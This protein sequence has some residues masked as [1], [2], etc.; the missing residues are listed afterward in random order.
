MSISMVGIALQKAVPATDHWWQF[1]ISA[2]VVMRVMNK[3]SKSKCFLT[4]LILFILP[5]VPCLVALPWVGQ[6]VDTGDFKDFLKACAGLLLILGPPC[7]SGSVKYFGLAIKGALFVEPTHLHVRD[8]LGREVSIKWEQVVELRILLHK[9]PPWQFS[10]SLIYI[11]DSGERKTV[12]IAGNVLSK[13]EEVRD[14]IIQKACL[15]EDPKCPL[16]WYVF[17]R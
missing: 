1:D 6:I 17:K 2:L 10:W 16:G 5:S 3:Y 7:W 14:I 15:S 13:P 12:G 4:A 8:W 9:R 11:T